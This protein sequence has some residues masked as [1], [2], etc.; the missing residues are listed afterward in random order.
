MSAGRANPK[1]LD[2]AHALL[3]VTGLGLLPD[4]KGRFREFLMFLH[5]PQDPR[6]KPFWVEVDPGFLGRLSVRTGHEI[7]YSSG[8][9]RQL[10]E[11]LVSSGA[12]QI[13]RPSR[14]LLVFGEFLPKVV[15]VDLEEH[16]RRV[17]RRRG[18]RWAV[19]DECLVMVD[20]TLVC[21]SFKGLG[22][23]PRDDPRVDI[24]LAPGVGFGGPVEDLVALEDYLMIAWGAKLRTCVAGH[25][26]LTFGR[27]SRRCCPEHRR[28]MNTLQVRGLRGHKEAARLLQELGRQ[29]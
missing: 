20:S 25:P 5:P 23:V 10:L 14:Q 29:P 21:H 7:S 1:L 18:L 4:V 11:K 13:M 3:L 26:Y 8:V 28:W 27:Q 17:I 19:G 6:P 12:T 16:W 9:N 22:P 2:R 15:R 24:K